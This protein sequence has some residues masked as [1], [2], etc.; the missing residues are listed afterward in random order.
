MRSP[1]VEPD[2]SQST[3][4]G[5]ASYAVDPANAERVVVG[6]EIQVLHHERALVERAAAGDTDA[7]E[8]L[9]GESLRTLEPFNVLHRVVAPSGRD[10]LVEARGRFVVDDAG[11]LVRFELDVSYAD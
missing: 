4:S 2:P 5:V 1:V 7:F 3:G 6:R 9:M 8:R 10:R 11:N